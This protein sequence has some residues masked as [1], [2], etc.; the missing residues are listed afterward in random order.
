MYHTPEFNEFTAGHLNQT[1]A[2]VNLA[3]KYDIANFV[4]KTDFDE[5]LKI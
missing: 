4:K 2:Q 1:L 3:S 5:K